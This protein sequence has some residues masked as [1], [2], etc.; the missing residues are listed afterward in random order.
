[1]SDEPS[2]LSEGSMIPWFQTMLREKDARI[3]YLETQNTRLL[4]AVERMTKEVAFFSSQATKPKAPPSRPVIAI[5]QA[6]GTRAVREMN[7]TELQQHQADLQEL[8]I[9]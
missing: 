6:D 4:D 1:M 3:G 9:L 7:D 2:P 8:G 5:E